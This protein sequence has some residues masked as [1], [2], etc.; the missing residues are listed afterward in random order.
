MKSDFNFQFSGIQV[1]TKPIHFRWIGDGTS[2][3]IYFR[4]GWGLQHCLLLNFNIQ[5]QV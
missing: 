4:I 3:T 5:S 2:H 1:G